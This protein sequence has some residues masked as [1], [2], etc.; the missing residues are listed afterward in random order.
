MLSWLWTSSDKSEWII[1][2][3]WQTQQPPSHY[4][5]SDI[6]EYFIRQ[7]PKFIAPPNNAGIGNYKEYYWYCFGQF[8]PF[9]V[10]PYNG[11]GNILEYINV[12]LKLYDTCKGFTRKLIGDPT[13]VTLLRKTVDTRNLHY[14]KNH[15]FTQYDYDYSR[16]HAH[17]VVQYSLS[18]LIMRFVSNYLGY[19]EYRKF[20]PVIDV[21]KCRVSY[22]GHFLGH[23][24]FSKLTFK[25]Q[26]EIK[27]IPLPE[28]D[29]SLPVNISNGRQLSNVDHYNC[30]G[31]NFSWP[32]DR[33]TMIKCNICSR[34]CE[35][36]WGKYKACL[37]CYMNRVC[38]KCGGNSI[39]T[40][41]DGFPRCYVH[42]NL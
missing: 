40:A 17:T 23:N 30:G 3:K 6:Y 20:Q 36:L 1:W 18:T 37:D 28:K 13:S 29:E 12:L 5:K 10:T 22:N 8:T 33:T 39:I 26:Q 38:Y 27:D 11:G 32:T 41:P 14:L 2:E 9:I 4:E 16:L 21:E 15:D 35:N 42:Q 24:R 7:E 34:V 31:H 19:L 25:A